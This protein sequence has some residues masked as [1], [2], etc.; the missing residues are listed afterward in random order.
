MKQLSTAMLVACL[1]THTYADTTPTSNWTGAFGFEVWGI[2][3]NWDNGVPNAAG[4][5][6]VFPASVITTPTAVSLTNGPYTL[7]ILEYDG[8]QPLEFEL[9]SLVFD[10]DGAGAGQA[11]ILLGS[12]TSTSLE[13]DSAILLNDDLHV[14]SSSGGNQLTFQRTLSGAG[15]ITLSGSG[16]VEFADLNT[17]WTGQ[18]D[19]HDNI[20]AIVSTPD[21]LG[22]TLAG[23]VLHS[24]ELV[25]NA[26][27][28]ETVTVNDG[29]ALL[30]NPGGTIGALNSNGGLV[31]QFAASAPP[32]VLGP[33]N[34]QWRLN[35]NNIFAAPVAG[36][37]DLTVVLGQATTAFQSSLDF[38]GGLTL[39]TSSPSPTVNFNG[40]ST[41]TGLTTL[42]NGTYNLNHGQGLGSDVAGTT[43]NAGTININAATGETFTL[44]SNTLLN[45]LPGTGIGGFDSAGTVILDA[46]VSGDSVMQA[47]G[48]V[49][50]NAGGSLTVLTSFGGDYIQRIPGAVPIHLA[51]GNTNVFRNAL[52]IDNTLSG[53][54]DVTFSNASTISSANSHSGTTTLLDDFT[55]AHPLGFGTSDGPTVVGDLASNSRSVLSVQV[56]T[57]EPFIVNHGHISFDAAAGVQTSPLSLNNST[58]VHAPGGHA[59]PI[60]IQGQPALGSG[61][62]TGPISGD[63]D[64]VLLLSGS[65]VDPLTVIDAANPYEGTA[66]MYL[67]DVQFNRPDVFNQAHRLISNP[68]ELTLVNGIDRTPAFNSEATLITANDLTLNGLWFLPKLGGGATVSVDRAFATALEVSNAPS[69]T[70]LDVSEYLVLTGG[71]GDVDT[72]S[73][74]GDIIVLDGDHYGQDLSGFSGDLV[75]VHGRWLGSSSKV[76]GG[77]NTT[78]RFAP[79]SLSE[80]ID[81][82]TPF[83]QPTTIVSQNIDATAVDVFRL[84]GVFAGEITVSPGTTIFGGQDYE[85]LTLQ[86][87]IIG[88]DVR[89][90][91][92]TLSGDD[93][94]GLTG[95]L[96]VSPYVQRNQFTTRSGLVRLADQTQLLDLD[97]VVIEGGS[98]LF[99]ANNSLG[100][101]A[102]RLADS[103]P[104]HSHNSM[105]LMQN[106]SVPQLTERVG[107]LVLKSGRTIVESGNS[108]G[109]QNTLELSGLTREGRSTVYFV[110]SRAGAEVRLL[111]PPVVTGEMIGPWAFTGDSTGIG[112]ATVDAQGNIVQAAPTSTDLNTAS[113]SDI[114][115][116]N[117]NVTLTS[118]KTVKAITGTQTSNDQIDLGG[119]TLTVETGGIHVR[120]GMSIS[121]GTLTSG[122]DELVFTAGSSVLG[123]NADITDNGSPVAVVLDLGREMGLSGN[124]TYTGGTWVYNTDVTVTQPNAIPAGGDITLIN[125]MFD[126]DDPNNG[127]PYTFGTITLEQDSRWEGGV[128][129]FETLRLRHGDFIPQAI[130]GDGVILVDGQSRARLTDQLS[131]FTG[132]IRVESGFLEVDYDFAQPI[133]ITL[134]GGVFYNQDDMIE[135]GPAIVLNGGTL[136]GDGY[137]RDIVVTDESALAGASVSS[138]IIGSHKLTIRTGLSSRPFT[139]LYSADLTN[140]TGDLLVETG[141]LRIAADSAGL[142]PG[143]ITVLQGAELV[144]AF[145]NGAV[146]PADNTIL[147]QS[148]KLTG[149]GDISHL[150]EVTFEG[151][152]SLVPDNIFWGERFDLAGTVRLGDELSLIGDPE[153]RA[154]LRDDLRLSG[155]VLVGHDVRWNPLFS[156]IEITGTVRPESNDASLLFV[157]HIEV[158]GHTATYHTE[159]GKTLTLL[160][161]I[162]PGT[163]NLNSAGR[164]MGDGT[165]RADVTATLGAMIAPGDDNPTTGGELTID[166][167]LTIGDGGVLSIWL[168]GDQPGAFTSALVLGDAVLDADALLSV[169]LS[170]AYLPAPTDSFTILTADSLVGLF[171]NAPQTIRADDYLFQVNYFSDRVVLSDPVFIPEPTSLAILSLGGLLV[172][173]RR[174][175][176]TH[177]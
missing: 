50:L 125:S 151:I 95:T 26:A 86:G 1:A 87:P 7:G 143:S 155:Q 159:S 66:W 55:L 172:S 99:L 54:G 34:T 4:N 139:S 148:G 107:E 110:K 69:P 59:G 115:A 157:G 79:N 90:T 177:F 100:F 77:P 119:H 145:K 156:N 137:R 122:T 46:A 78:I 61:V 117:G 98:T 51:G 140:Y 162:G 31:Q 169:S 160:D 142:G 49:E 38:D 167:E 80:G 132:E 27:T 134:N 153:G 85:K 170:P 2:P 43:L 133:Q 126:L 45:V 136:T 108:S 5:R 11:Q 88:Q 102:D 176:Q 144:L 21:A 68:I 89:L 3:A 127:V 14:Q 131:G 53:P 42:P 103:T 36:T 40:A 106:G 173:R 37:G 52:E 161:D 22:D 158:P 33:G 171:E 71:R 93:F 152:A 39:T 121:N 154:D 96:T 120:S 130:V 29:G 8:N 149:I 123:L 30:L 56:L 65:F 13:F 141:Q 72:V 105:I 32:T 92:A 76:F 20:R 35:S 135:A 17:A 165:L 67:W 97:L 48:Q 70:T 91:S 129:D 57:D 6:A 128:V 81:A 138:A 166:G 111:N 16:V 104:I 164:L 44:G 147:I 150:G 114:V 63:S 15:N 23:T 163:L 64:S 82:I 174:R 25:V 19:I 101:N 10:Q 109:L 58:S 41:Y 75:L 94:S 113:A 12:V 28:H 83:N 175:S 116:V 112:F 62:Y 118:S 73:G 74:T 47:G 146:S 84:Q 18:L 24:G 60:S 9:G 168:G 124:M